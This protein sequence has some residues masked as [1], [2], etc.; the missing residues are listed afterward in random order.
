M[1]EHG[2]DFTVKRYGSLNLTRDE[3]LSGEEK[4]CP[5]W[6]GSDLFLFT[7]DL[8]SRNAQDMHSLQ[9]PIKKGS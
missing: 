3:S 1:A 8:G 7:G 2:L 9:L 5:P 6:G 4:R